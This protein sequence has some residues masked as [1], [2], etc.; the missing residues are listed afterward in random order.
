MYSR[1]G[2]F[3]AII[4]VVWFESF[5]L[6]ALFAIISFP[7]V[8]TLEKRAGGSGSGYY[9]CLF[10]S[11]FPLLG[12]YFASNGVKTN[13][14]LE[15]YANDARYLTKAQEANEEAMEPLCATWRIILFLFLMLAFPKIFGFIKAMGKDGID[16]KV[17][18]TLTAA[19][20][21]SFC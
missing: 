11:L 8:R 10:F 20:Y 14:Y 9:V 1:D 18:H 17:R 12:V 4:P 7:V 19:Q 3:P 16:T 5:S 6:F 13:V 15:V 2:Y 21:T